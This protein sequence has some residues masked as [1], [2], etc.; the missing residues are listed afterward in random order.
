MPD[1]Y[2]VMPGVYIVMPGV[3]IVMPGLTGHLL[4]SW[5]IRTLKLER[6][7]LVYQ[8]AKHRLRLSLVTI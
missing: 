3:Y 5:N 7:I 4:P 2:I 1:V 8:S 6:T